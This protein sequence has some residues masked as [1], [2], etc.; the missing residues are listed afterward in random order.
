M[1]NKIYIIATEQEVNGY[2]RTLHSSFRYG[3][4]PEE[5]ET[6]Y[7]NFK[8]WVDE[9]SCSFCF[10]RFDKSGKVNAV[11][12][13]DNYGTEH[14]ITHKDFKNAR[15]KTRVI[16]Y[17]LSDVCMSSLAKELSATEFLQL[18]KDNGVGIKP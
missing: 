7:D 17:D 6:T 2:K 16:E 15:A 1:S 5:T 8:D 14:K 3:D 9:T 12:F 13:R 10:K 11:Y 4:L 18:L